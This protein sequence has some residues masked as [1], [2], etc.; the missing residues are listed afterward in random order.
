MTSASLS[1]SADRQAALD[2]LAWLTVERLGY[3]LALLLAAG[4]RL[5]ALGWQPLAPEEARQAMAALDWVRGQTSLPP[6][7]SSPLLLSLHYFTFLFFAATEAWARLWPALAG[8]LAV[9][10]PY[11]LRR[12]LGRGAA[13]AASFLLALSGV[14]AFWSRSATG[15][16]FAFAA[17]LALFV[18]LAGLRRTGG[19]PW[20]LATGAG[21]AALL[22]SAPVSYSLLLA[23]AVALIVAGR[24]WL[25]T[26]A[27][28]SRSRWAEAGLAFGLVVLLGSTAFLVRPGGLAALADLPAAWLRQWTQGGGYPLGVLVLRF[29]LVEPL[30]LALGLLGL[31]WGVRKRHPLT[32]LLGLWLAVGAAL[33]LR[34]GRTPADLGVL[35]LPLA[36]L[37][38]QAVASFARRWREVEARGQTTPLLATLAV[39]TVILVFTAIWLADYA[40]STRFPQDNVFLWFA[41]MGVGLL[42]ALVAFY[43]LWW[44]AYGAATAAGLLLVAA[45][46]VL[47][48]RATWEAT[49]NTDGLRWGSLRTTVGAP[50]GP[51]L[52]A[53]LAQL[54]AQDQ[55]YG[56][57]LFMLEVALVVPPGTEPDPLLRW[58]LRDAQVRIVPGAGSNTAH[59][60]IVALA[61]EALPLGEGFAG[62]SFRLTQSW[63]PAQLAGH[64]RWRWLLFGH[65]GAPAAEQRAVVWVRAT[66]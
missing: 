50:D 38:G 12:E 45:L 32:P 28:L 61:G 39:G 33:L 55:P 27:Q 9:L 17:G 46:T 6:A 58:Y 42:L 24:D 36:L 11:G 23:L 56:T 10:L 15:E 29:V 20:A 22:A 44:D 51:N 47:S 8:A 14:L 37:G 43:V 26:V 49:H 25:Q 40:A 30:L 59:R 65:Y 16:S 18:S 4:I 63:S 66:P 2:L 7:G 53:F 57:D 52:T 62:R 5:T 60:L 13:L 34:P 31:A 1:P 54:A 41:A 19:R 35:S 48:V 64:A 21:L 3:G